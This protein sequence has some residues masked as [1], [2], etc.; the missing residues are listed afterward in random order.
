[1]AELIWTVKKDE[2]GKILRRK[3]EGDELG[4]DHVDVEWTCKDGKFPAD[5]KEVPVSHPPDIKFK[6]VPAGVRDVIMD[7]LS[8]PPHVSDG[9]IA[10]MLDE[11]KAKL[12][13]A[14]GVK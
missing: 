4:L 1:M 10:L 6:T 12:A 9:T 5:T 7:Q 2:G 11:K 14:L 13:L 8:V 3:T